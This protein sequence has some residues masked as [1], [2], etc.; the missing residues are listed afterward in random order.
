MTVESPFSEC[1]HAYLAAGRALLLQIR[2]EPNADH[3]S[4]DAVISKIEVEMLADC[5]SLNLCRYSDEPFNTD[6]IIWPHWGMAPFHT[7]KLATLARSSCCSPQGRSAFAKQRLVL[8]ETLPDLKVM[9]AALNPRSS[10]GAFCGSPFWRFI[11]FEA[12]IAPESPFFPELA[13]LSTYAPGAST[14]VLPLL[15]SP[16][17]P[18]GLPFPALDAPVPPPPPA[19]NARLGTKIS[20]TVAKDLRLIAFLQILEMWS[21]DMINTRW[22][23]K[24]YSKRTCWHCEEVYNVWRSTAP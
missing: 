4:I 2:Q 6:Q 12:P 7:P 11:S 22:R 20:A 13:P 17:A 3:K 16:L 24:C 10:Y 9:N 19:A 21:K 14:G 1:A 8:R 15:A 23:K 5:A 18:P